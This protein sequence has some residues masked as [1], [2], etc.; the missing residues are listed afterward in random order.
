MSN[1]QMKKE[2]DRV[3][4]SFSLL[5]NRS[6]MYQFD[7]PYTSQSIKD[8]FRTIQTALNFQNPLVLIMNRDQFFIEDEPLDPRLN[9][10]RMVSHF[11]KAGVQSLSFH[12]GI[13]SNDRDCTPAFLK[14]DTIRV[15]FSLGSR[16]SSSMKN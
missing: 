10:T 13:Q 8:F 3:G 16:G 12:E 5:F 1:A 2:F 7:H 6:T 14:C 11:K 9:V 4:R 15:T